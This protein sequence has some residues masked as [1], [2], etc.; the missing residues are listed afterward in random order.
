MA[1]KQCATSRILFV[2]L[3]VAALS[4]AIH[5]L[6][7]RPSF[8]PKPTLLNY[9]TKGQFAWASSTTPIPISTVSVYAKQ[10]LSHDVDSL[11]APLH[12]YIPQDDT[13]R[14]QPVRD[15]LN[16]QRFDTIRRICTT[17]NCDV[18]AVDRKFGLTPLHIAYTT[19]DIPLVAWLRGRGA[20]EVNDHVGR[21]PQNLS[22][23]NFI[24]NAKSWK[25][26]GED[27]DF[28]IVDFEGD[29]EHAKREVRRL[30]GEGEPILMRGA[31]KLYGGDKEGA[32][33]AKEWVERFRDVEVTVGSVP[34]AGAFNLATSKM[35]LQAYYE[36]FV[37][38]GSNQPSY[39]F[40]K[41]EGVCKV[42]YETLTHLIED[43]FPGKLIAHPD[44]TGGIDGIHFFFG[45]R[46]SGAP[47]HVHAD[48]INASVKGRK[49][50][51]VLTPGRTLYSR[52]PVKTWI[53]EDYP[54]LNDD[55]KP[56][57]CVQRSGDVVYVPLDWGHAVSNLDDDTFGYA[58][59]VLNR[60]DT[61]SHLAR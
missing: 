45:R 36:D 44:E 18:N 25:R 29:L 43:C 48:A 42:G 47:F 10:L 12:K 19:N 23:T 15:Y 11:P 17:T 34:Y 37:V 41:H 3:F 7:P 49:K 46:D 58:L 2:S 21:P 54:K 60:R 33:N 26:E 5:F 16:K 40:N 51:F 13:L 9:L 22:F 32:W 38:K 35:T 39:V 8:E 20:R 27:C 14:L 6:L 61:F 59:E 57:E 1:P 31:Y 56:L 52:K 50:W 30:V 28:P 55:D 53:D 24:R 4:T